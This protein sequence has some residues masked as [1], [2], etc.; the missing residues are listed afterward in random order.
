L[1]VEKAQQ[2]RALVSTGDFEEAERIC[3]QA[4]AG[5]PDDPGI[6]LEL[7]KCEQ[8]R[9]DRESALR[10]FEHLLA[11]APEHV[12]ALYHCGSL[13]LAEDRAADATDR[14]RRC[15]SLDPNHAPARTALARIA[16]NQGR[17]DEARSGFRSAL[18]A[19][20]DEVLALLGLAEV[21][22]RTGDIDGAH[23]SA[24]RALKLKPDGAAPQLTMA[25]VFEAQ[26][27][28]DFAEQCLR[29]AGANAPRDIRFPLALASL[30]QRQDRHRAALEVIGQAEPDGAEDPQMLSAKAISLTCVGRLVEARALYE[31]L[32]SSTPEAEHFL[33]LADIYHEQRDAESLDALH[34][35]SA[36]LP[37][38]MREWFRALAAAVRGQTDEILVRVRGILENGEPRITMQARL[39]AS[40]VL[41]SQGKVLE[42]E[43]FLVPLVR[44]GELPGAL[45]WE[46]ARMCRAAELHELAV[47]LLD[48][49]MEDSSLDEKTRQ[50]VNLARLDALD[51]AGRY[52]RANELMP[53]VAG[54]APPLNL[55]RSRAQENRIAGKD[56]LAGVE[57]ME[58]PR[59]DSIDAGTGPIFVHGCPDSGRELLVETL[60][61]CSGA[62]MLPFERW[63]RRREA[64]DLPRSAREAGAL[65]SD[66]LALIRHRYLRGHRQRSELRSLEP[67]EIRAAD[68][69]LIARV[70]PEAS[71]IVVQIAE[72]SLEL[73][74]RLKG[75]SD[76]PG[77]LSVWRDEKAMLQRCRAFL[78]LHFVDVSLANLTDDPEA[79]LLPMAETLRLQCAPGLPEKLAQWLKD[80][81]YRSRDHWKHYPLIAGDRANV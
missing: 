79:S 71:I 17:L 39:L 37:P 80:S 13:M 6:L 14:L 32:I 77:M 20:P 19:D 22:L 61:Q 64:L 25:R 57:K 27:H 56:E 72:E 11:L 48:R 15:V 70:F 62:V 55:D 30:L 42:V 36:M 66:R 65:D 78:P 46:A 1:T 35:R 63:P 49:L 12:E 44:N 75:Y 28:L 47:E 50:Q 52:A 9:G 60:S 7:A 2:A 81:G 59:E 3:V 34:T 38:D 54:R 45:G 16:L 51:R 26:G 69:P 5:C 41:L 29:N 73:Q 67:G 43:Q 58:W 18:R 33:Q 74:W 4:L 68:L 21:L 23:Q 53:G 8:Q 40:S 31:R 10:H 24:S 76:I